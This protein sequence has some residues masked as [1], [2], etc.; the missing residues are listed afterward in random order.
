MF[1]KTQLVCHTCQVKPESYHRILSGVR[2]VFSQRKVHLLWA[3][4]NITLIGLHRTH[5]S[6]SRKIQCVIFLNA[7]TKTIRYTRSNKVV[8]CEHRYYT[9]KC[10]CDVDELCKTS[11][12]TSPH[13]T[14]PSLQENRSSTSWNKLKF[15]SF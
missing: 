5:S 2:I 13:I 1:I 8:T 10:C 12:N 9:K 4:K 6:S 15:M 7:R 3:H 14:P 11:K